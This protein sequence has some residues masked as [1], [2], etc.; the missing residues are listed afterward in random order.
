[1]CLTERKTREAVCFLLILAGIILI[2][3]GVYFLY[4]RRRYDQVIA[5]KQTVILSDLRQVIPGYAVQGDAVPRGTDSGDA[6]SGDTAFGEAAYG[7][8]TLPESGM[9]FAVVSVD[10]VDCTG[11]LQIPSLELEV[12]VAARYSSPDYMA[13][14]AED[15]TENGSFSIASENRDSL[16]GR[17]TEIR[18]QNEV[19]FTDVRG[20]RYAYRVSAV[21]TAD[22]IPDGMNSEKQDTSE[23]NPTEQD[24]GEQNPTG[25]NVGGHNSP[26][27]SSNDQTPSGK[28]SAEQSLTPVLN[29]C[30][31]QGGKWF[32]AECTGES[33]N[34]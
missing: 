34:S 24:S 15:V 10:G 6:A 5:K 14:I 26:E 21:Y 1:M 33:L 3:G 30:C 29:L 23:Q 25:Q 12:A 28:S 8:S 32:V 4:E 13:Y 27:Q 16:L 11:I 7:N 9:D 18:E 17:I 19:I 31:P 20:S 2:I 22:E